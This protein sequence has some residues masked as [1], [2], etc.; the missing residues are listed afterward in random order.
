MIV[1]QSFDYIV[2]IKEIEGGYGIATDRGGFVPIKFSGRIASFHPGWEPKF[3]Y[4]GFAPIFLLELRNVNSSESTW[5]LDGD[6]NFLAA[7]TPFQLPDHAGN[8]VRLKAAMIFAKIWDGLAESIKPDL[9]EKTMSFFLINEQTRLSIFEYAWPAA[10]FIS[11]DVDLSTVDNQSKFMASSGRDFVQIAPDDLSGILSVDLQQVFVQAPAQKSLV[12]KSPVDGR[13][14]ST[15][16]S[17][18]FDDFRFA[19]R[20]EDRGIIFYVIAALHHCRTLGLYFPKERRIFYSGKVELETI[21]QYYG[22]SFGKFLMNHFCKFGHLI[23]DYLTAP[24]RQLS[25][26]TRFTHIGHDLRNELTGLDTFVNSTPSSLIPEVIAFRASVGSELYGRT[27]DIFPELNGKIRRDIADIHTLA[28]HV[29]QERRCIMHVTGLYVRTRL[30]ERILRVSLDERLPSSETDRLTDIRR[31]GHPII[32]IGLRVENRTIIDLADFCVHVVR[33]ILSKTHGCTIVI[34]GHSALNPEC[35]G[36]I[37]ASF[38]EEL[39]E[40]SPIKI[41][42]NIVEIIKKTFEGEKIS[43]I[44]NIGASMRQSIFWC[45]HAD[46][47]IAIGGSGLAKYRWVCNTPG[48][49][50]TNRASFETN[51]EMRIY[52]SPIMEKSSPLWFL[53]PNFIEDMPDSPTLVPLPGDQP[54]EWNCNFRVREEGLFAHISAMLQNYGQSR[55]PMGAPADIL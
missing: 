12:W 32:L 37:F 5:F 16:C 31:S 1:K 43:I 15:D 17:L 20:I 39:A 22:D 7:D 46:F 14:I 28:R 11:S 8:H 24:K 41:E 13:V 40:T 45:C 35:G 52:E 25:I 2:P 38:Q 19:Y 33:F 18:C 9:D 51:G 21:M 53:E 29:Y 34:D 3:L 10:S 50:I 36:T 49:I 42:K 55:D 47:F 30:R 27:E 6:L 54:V 26:F 44:D 48:L 23:K 4:S